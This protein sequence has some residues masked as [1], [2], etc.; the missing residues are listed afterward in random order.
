[1]KKYLFPFFLALLLG[2]FMSCF[3]LGQYNSDGNIIISKKLEQIYYINEGVYTSLDDMQKKM[4]EFE[5]YIYSKEGDVYY[6]Y[7]GITKNKEN[8]EKIKT[9][10]KSKGYETKILEKNVSNEGFLVVLGQYDNILK[11]TENEETIRV[12]CNQVLA[13]Y[14]ET[15]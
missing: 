5:N 13:K 8:A 1:M 14:E 11:E 9:Y 7:V 10:F 4:L 6:T 15:N 12:I 2:L 3:F